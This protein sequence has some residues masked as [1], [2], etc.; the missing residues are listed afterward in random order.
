MVIKVGSSTLMFP[1]L[2]ISLCA[3]LS[4]DF[5]K[6]LGIKASIYLHEGFSIFSTYAIK[7]EH[8][9]NGREK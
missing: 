2:H 4:A 1:D 8:F 3:G 6:R 5:T 9:F 7:G